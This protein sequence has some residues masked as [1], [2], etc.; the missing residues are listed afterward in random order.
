MKKPDE[1]WR[2]KLTPEEFEVCRRKCT[3]RAFTGE[4]YLSKETGTYLCKCCGEALFTS[5]TKYESG[6]GWPSF[7]QSLPDKV[8]TEI[9]STHG[10]DR[11]EIKCTK[12]GSHL[13][14]IFEDGPTPTGQRFCVNSLSLKLEKKKD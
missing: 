2:E 7:F 8:E 10:M 6:S 13:G 4:Y 14:H 9:D 11:V 5:D 3:E 12:C 1:F